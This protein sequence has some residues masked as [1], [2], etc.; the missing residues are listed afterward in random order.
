MW[1]L[2]LGYIKTDCC[3]V[4]THASHAWLWNIMSSHSENTASLRPVDLPSIYT[5]QCRQ[6]A[7]M[8]S[9]HHQFQ[10]TSRY[11]LESC[12]AQSDKYKFSKIPVFFWKLNFFLL[13][14]TAS[15][16]PWSDAH[17]IH[18]RGMSVKHPS[19]NYC[20][21]SAFQVK[22][23]FI[24]KNRRLAFSSTTRVLFSRQP[25]YP[26]VQ[27]MCRLMSFTLEH[28]KCWKALYSQYEI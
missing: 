1:N 4:C 16:F 15:C 22:I 11:I 23:V 27:P 28:I 12:Q 20:S 7:H 18:F 6:P 2:R 8:H 17:I 14:A 9:Y 3:S 13:L 24:R 19:L 5:F 25:L 10:H 26:R 21:M